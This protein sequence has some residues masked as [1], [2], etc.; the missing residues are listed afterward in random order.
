MKRIL[1]VI[2]LA[3]FLCTSVWFAGNAILPDLI[4]DLKLE[5]NFLSHLTSAVQFGFIAG[6]LVF[7]FSPLQIDFL[8][9]K[10]S[11]LVH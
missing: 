3:Q 7:A 8:P 11:S 4:T 6:T 5:S 1:F 2:V 10:S 9:P